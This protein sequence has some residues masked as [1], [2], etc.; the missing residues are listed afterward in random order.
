MLVYKRTSSLNKD[1]VFCQIWLPEQMEE[2]G[3]LEETQTIALQ[4]SYL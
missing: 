4:S 1:Y 3:S 2:L